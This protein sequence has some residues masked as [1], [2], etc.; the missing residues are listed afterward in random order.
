MGTRIADRGVRSWTALSVVAALMC[1]GPLEA[2][3]A[4]QGAQ[5]TTP[6]QAVQVLAPPQAPAAPQTQSGPVL[7]LTME[8]AVAMAVDAN[9]GLKFQRLNVDIAAE[10]V[11]GA[12]AAFKPF[13][14]AQVTTSSSTRL[15][16]TFTDLTSGSI[17]SSGQQGFVQVNQSLPWLGGTYTAQ[18]SNSR[19]TTNQ[20]LAVFNPALS[21]T[22]QFNFRQPLLRNLLIDPNRATLENSQTQRQVADLDLELQTI[23]LQNAVRQ[24]YLGLKAANAQLDVAKQ[25]FD[26]AQK[27]FEDNKKKVSVGVAANSDIIQAQVQVEQQQGFV[28][29]VQGLVAAAQ[30]T[31][32]TLILDPS[33]ADYWTVQIEATD[34]IVVQPREIDIEAAVKTALANRLDVQEAQR[35]LEITK[36]TTRLDENLTTTQIDALAQYS[37]TSS[38]GT[39]FTYDLSGAVANTAVKGLSSVLGQTFSGAFPTWSVGVQVGY[40]VGRNAAEATLAQQRLVQR[41]AELNLHILQLNV[42]AGVRQAARDVQ[43]NYQVVQASHAALQAA[44][45]QLEDEKRMLE[46]GL[47]NTFELLQKTAILTQARTQDIQAQIFYNSA[48]LAFDRQLKVK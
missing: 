5:T 44:E 22:V 31:L 36:R 9:L 10:G 30:D 17:S 13:L 25:N 35:N 8:Q 20:Q 38:G 7:Q 19:S 40:P 11:A 27:Q 6:P 45:K 18:W 48:L 2:A 46:V 3:G 29:Q 21:S 42:A 34:P 37:A 39:Q 43:T 15:P 4:G 14:Q 12:S 47:S 24:A 33:R 41:Q 1:V 26:T 23:T 28:F 32:R 16:Q